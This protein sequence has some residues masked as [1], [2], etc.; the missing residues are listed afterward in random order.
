MV[1]YDLYSL[2]LFS[3]VAGLSFFFADAA[4][5]LVEKP[6][7]NSLSKLK[8]LYTHAKDLSESEVK[9]VHFRLL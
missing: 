8:A 2:V 5:E 4:P 3:F 6:G 9:Y 7:D 1:Q